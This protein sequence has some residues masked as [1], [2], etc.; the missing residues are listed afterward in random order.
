MFD[1]SSNLCPELEGIGT[2]CSWLF[3]F[4]P[5]RRPIAS[6]SA[7][8]VCLPPC[9]KHQEAQDMQCTTW[10]RHGS[11]VAWWLFAR[12]FLKV[13]CLW[14]RLSTVLQAIQIY[15]NAKSCLR[16]H[17]LYLICT[18]L[19]KAWM[20]LSCDVASKWPWPSLDMVSACFWIASRTSQLD[21]DVFLETAYH[22]TTSINIVLQVVQ[23]GQEHIG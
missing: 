22:G 7:R 10:A 5:S 16:K 4:N 13:L 18:S 11:Q 23:N 6:S 9:N 2:W 3:I 20:K 21:V 15:S 1:L 17:Q 12:L 14:G 19:F 8:V